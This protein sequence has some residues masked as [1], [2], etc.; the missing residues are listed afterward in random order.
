MRI[1]SQILLSIAAPV[2]V[3]SLIA[4][5]IACTGTRQAIYDILRQTHARSAQMLARH[6]EFAL[7]RRGRRPL[8]TFMRSLRQAPTVEYALVANSRGR[9]LA[10]TEAGFEGKSVAQWRAERAMD[11][12]VEL[13]APA[14]LPGGEAGLALV[15]LH[16]DL[17]NDLLFL[18]IVLYLPYF[19]TAGGAILLLGF[20][21]AL[22]L[23]GLLTRPIER[24][25]RASEKI[26]AGDLSVVVPLSSSTELSELARQFNAMA[27]RLRELDDLKDAFIAQ[28]SHDL[29]SPMGAIKMYAEYLL[30]MDPEREK[31]GK[32][33]RQMLTTVMENAMRLNVFVSNIL[34]SAKMKAGRMEYH[35]QP[36]SVKDALGRL[37]GL[38][39]LVARQQGIRLEV[40]LP[41]DLPP[42]MVD[43]E[44]LDQILA[45]L[46]SNAFKFTKAS[47]QVT[48]SARASER[49][50]EVQVADTGKGISPKNLALL[51]DSY[52]QVD[53]ASQ[54]SE[55]VHGTGLGLYIVKRAAE[56]MGGSVRAESE[57]G[58]G[59]RFTLEFPAAEEA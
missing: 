49:R 59:T 47:G 46:V 33:Q 38:Y 21:M 15:G 53:V 19:L 55:S 27:A 40:S 24:L 41:P 44:R 5:L 54:R 8:D 6:A 58:K 28:V 13:I 11:N 2:A 48:I 42:L 34:D 26:A 51:F 17:F 22:A 45:N 4:L 57:L 16:P 14:R 50:V 30:E 20:F 37:A 9:I 7:E 43:P 31:L 29:R 56:A 12:P 10:H 3:C 18:L 23:S 39:G 25:L 36:T 1:R 35:P 32:R 52:R